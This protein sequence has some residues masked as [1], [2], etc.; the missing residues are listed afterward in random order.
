[1][2]IKRDTSYLFYDKNLTCLPLPLSLCSLMLLYFQCSKVLVKST[3]H[4]YRENTYTYSLTE[5]LTGDHSVLQIV[6]G[7]AS[8]PDFRK[9]LELPAAQLE[10]A[11]Q[12][13]FLQDPLEAPGELLLYVAAHVRRNH[14]HITFFGHT[15]TLGIDDTTSA[16][17][18]R[19]RDRRETWSASLAFS[20]GDA[21]RSVLVHETA[22]R[23]MHTNHT[24]NTRATTTP[25]HLSVRYG[26]LLVTTGRPGRTA[27]IRRRAA[28]WLWRARACARRRARRRHHGDRRR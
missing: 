22:R 28:V 25:L 4:N 3:L 9:I 6:F 13:R 23:R 2:E 26:A 14:R 11:A 18:D 7:R 20:L 15:F 1:M 17:R 21:L 24:N 5:I 27:T 12:M 8:F 16:M 10:L 19:D